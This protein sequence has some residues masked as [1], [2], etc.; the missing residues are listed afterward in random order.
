MVTIAAITISILLCAGLAQ[1]QIINPKDPNWPAPVWPEIFEPNQPLMNLNIQMLDPNDWDIIRLNGLLWDGMDYYEPDDPNIYLYELPAWF[2]A[3]GEEDKMIKVAVRQKS[4]IPLGDANDRYFKIALKVDINQYY[5]E[6]EFGDPNGDP[7]AVAHWHGL[8][9]LSLENGDDVDVVAEGLALNLHTMSSGAEGYGYDAW[10]GNWVTLTVEDINRGVYISAEQRNKQ[11]LTNRNLD[12]DPNNVWMYKVTGEN[13]T[14]LKV[15]DKD[16]GEVPPDYPESP[17]YLALN[18]TPFDISNPV[19]DDATLVADMNT[20]VDMQSLLTMGAI[21][22][23]VANSDSLFSHYQNTYFLDFNLPDPCETRKRMYLP[24]DVDSTMNSLDWD[25]YDRAGDVTTWQDVFLDSP[26]YRPQYNQITRDLM[27]VSLN[28]SNIHSFLDMMLPILHDALAA[29]PYNQFDVLESP[30]D[31]V[32]E[33]FSKVKTWYSDRV[34]NVLDQLWWDEPVGTVLLN[35]GFEGTP[36]NA[37]WNSGNWFQDGSDYKG[38][39]NCAKS[40]RNN[41]GPILSAVLDAND[42]TVIHVAFWVNKDALDPDQDAYLYYYNGTTFNNDL[43]L[44]DFD[45]LGSDKQWLRYTDVI[46]DSNYFTPEFRIIID[47]SL[48]TS[49]KEY[50]CLDDVKVTKLTTT[51]VDPIISGY[52]MDLKNEPVVGAVVSG[53][54]GGDSDVTDANGYYELTMPYGWS[55]TVEPNDPE[56]TFDPV[57]RTYTY[58]VIDHHERWVPDYKATSIYDFNGDGYINFLDYSVFAL[59]WG[60]SLGEGNW[61]PACDFEFSLHIDFEDLYHFVNSW[62]E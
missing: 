22:A 62:L 28:R 18:Y 16:S 48:L 10:R 6:D 30:L 58:V 46:T 29:D 53:N 21:N 17:G 20:Y 15:P 55:G 35:D 51:P 8:S 13:E 43:I 26:T 59:A 19:P 27:G 9:K 36:W 23:F 33:H 5:S 38:S 39:Y 14:L 3:D 4:N 54:N 25:I 45:V 32:D 12:D 11:F 1:A 37:N 31:S 50:I 42:A 56:Y 44:D 34:V 60:S 2:W 40:D 52:I 41:K 49:T 61:N 7:N 57:G 24:W 47:T